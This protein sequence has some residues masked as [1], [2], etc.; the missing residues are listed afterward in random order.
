MSRYCQNSGRRN[1]WRHLNRPLPVT[2]SLWLGQSQA[3]RSVRFLNTF[4]APSIPHYKPIEGLQRI[5]IFFGWAQGARQGAVCPK[6]GPE[7]AAF[8][9]LLLPQPVAVGHGTVATAWFE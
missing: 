2:P 9:C 5:I 6:A 7:T 4:L 1:S 3:S 8:C